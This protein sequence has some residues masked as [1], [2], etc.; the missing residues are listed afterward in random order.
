MPRGHTNN[1]N[2]RPK[3]KPN[4]S[5]EAAKKLFMEIMSRNVEKIQT[6]LDE[7]YEDDKARFLYVINKFFPYYMPRKEDITSG[8]EQI[9]PLDIS[10]VKEDIK[11]EIEKMINE[12][13]GNIRSKS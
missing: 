5:T 6:A 11:R 1:P 4:K 2:G 8:G 9:R 12:D 3:G 7:I 10:V 13:D